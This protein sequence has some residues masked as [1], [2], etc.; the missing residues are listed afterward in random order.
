MIPVFTLERILKQYDYRL[1]M[2][3]LLSLFL[4]IGSITVSG[5]KS[6]GAWEKWEFLFGEWAGEAAGQPGQGIGTFSFKPDLDGNILV[7]R[8]HTEFPAA[9]KRPAFNHDDLLIV[10]KNQAGF[11]S[12]AIYFDNENHTISYLVALTDNSVVFTSE[13]SGNVPRFRLTYTK[14]DTKK[15]NV[16]FEMASLQNPEKFK[17]YL[18][19]QCVRK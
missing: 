7:R 16:R 10:Y 18:E 14:L 13:V 9:N 5:Q 3:L 1:K 8:S 4:M 17:I 11:P 19:G 6:P 2:K 15:L 12:S